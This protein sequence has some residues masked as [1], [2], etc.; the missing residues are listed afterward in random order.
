MWAVAAVTHHRR[1][2][3]PPDGIFY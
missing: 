2:C 3:R 1:R